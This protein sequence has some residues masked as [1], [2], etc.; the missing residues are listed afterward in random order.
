[1]DAA[2]ELLYGLIHAR[3]ILTSKGLNAMVRSHGGGGGIGLV[4]APSQHRIFPPT[5]TV[6]AQFDKFQDVDFGRCSRVYCEGQPLLPVG[7]SDIPRKFTV[8]LYCP[9]C[10][11]I[12]YPRSSRHASECA[13]HPPRH[14]VH[15]AAPLQTRPGVSD[16]A[17]AHL[18]SSLPPVTS[19]R[20]G[21]AP[22]GLLPDSIPPPPS[23]PRP[24][25]LHRAQTSTART[26]APR[27]RTC[28]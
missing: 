20:D 10:N 28:S 9:R 22:C 11:D 25:S 23:P 7:Q 5:H 3:Y 1:V 24:C 26:L 27:S 19:R 14:A 13:G 4:P 15:R 6:R 17:F 16:R 2:A 8:T 18:S 12:Y 21:N